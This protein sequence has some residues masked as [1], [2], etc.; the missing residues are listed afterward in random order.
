MPL[1]FSS[2]FFLTSSFSCLL[3]G[4]FPSVRAIELILCRQGIR[5]FFSFGGSV[6]HTGWSGHC[7]RMLSSSG[8]MEENDM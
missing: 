5:E 2:F 6:Q 3:S 8:L 4:M 1:L 7:V